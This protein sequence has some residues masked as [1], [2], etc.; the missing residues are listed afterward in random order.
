MCVAP[1][2]ANPLH[3]SAATDKGKWHA[4]SSKMFQVLG[5]VGEMQADESQYKCMIQWDKRPAYPVLQVPFLL[6]QSQT[7]NP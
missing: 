4:P 1:S 2:Q 5:I 3:R 6:C 7:L